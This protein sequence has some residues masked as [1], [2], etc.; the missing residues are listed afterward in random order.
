M[1]LYKRAKLEYIDPQHYGGKWWLAPGP[2][3]TSLCAVR[4]LG[5]TIENSSID[6]L[7]VESGLYSDVVCNQIINGS[8]YNRAMEAH[9]TTLQVFTDLWLPTFFESR[10]RVYDALIADFSNPKCNLQ[11]GSHEEI[12]KAH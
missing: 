7:W 6:D 10:E 8:H 9:E 12:K 4:C 1:D 11:S 3:H 2:F 5:K